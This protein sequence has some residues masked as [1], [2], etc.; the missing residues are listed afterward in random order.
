LPVVA[1][2]AAL[3]VVVPDLVVS[4]SSP[5]SIGPVH[6]QHN[7]VTDW[8]LWNY[9]GYERKSSWAELHDGIVATL[10]RIDRRYGCGRAM[11]EYSSNLDRF[12]TP[13]ALMD[14]PMWT[15]GCIDSMEGLLFE[16]AASTPYHFLDQAEL[17]AAPD[18]AMV[19]LPY[20]PLDVALGVQHLQL[21]GVRYFLASSPSVQA[22]AD[23]DPALS[24]V[25]TTG[26]WRT[27]YQGQTLV[28]TWNIYVV[29]D[30][31]L[32]SPL[33][34]RPE[35]LVGVGPGQG[36]WLPVAERWYADPVLWA[37]ELTAGGPTSW[38]R[39]SGVPDAPEAA[40]SGHP[41]PTVRVSGV[42][43]SEDEI[44]F[45][46]DRVGV[47]VLVRV[48]YFPD[49]HVT[50]AAGPWRA[51]PNLMVVIPSAHDVTLRYGSSGAGRVGEVLFVAGLV[52]L[53]VLVRRRNSVAPVVR[54]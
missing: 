23:A 35:V 38:T 13:E 5:F 10:D 52:A 46:V 45:H 9:S 30:S 54:S 12:G 11:W 34:T 21:L 7:A 44:T 40:D 24:L 15:G 17:S 25:A 43:A 6:V 53:V 14:L 18:D 42:R 32:V 4:P 48:S 19:G 8:A 3:V 1:T 41:L 33:V 47:P 22:E 2:V 39:T 16:S 36:S 51:E 37:T 31:S 27:L 49:W 29:H 26:P 20:G 50:G 28:T